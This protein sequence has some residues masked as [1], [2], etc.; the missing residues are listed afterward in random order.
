M[1]LRNLRDY[2][3]ARATLEHAAWI[4]GKVYGPQYSGTSAVLTHLG[5]T[6]NDLGERNAAYELL[7]RALHIREATWGAQDVGVA[8]SLNRIGLLHWTH[9]DLSIAQDAPERAALINSRYDQQH[10]WVALTQALLGGVLLE[11][12]ETAV[13]LQLLEQALRTQ[14]AYYGSNHPTIADILILLTQANPDP[15]SAS[16]ARDRARRIHTATCGSSDPWPRL[17]FYGI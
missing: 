8:H 5:A 12:G 13:G 9:G 6:L 17:A 10:P 4:Y 11:L 3:A 2:P 16:R 1:T 15:V 7:D 14:E